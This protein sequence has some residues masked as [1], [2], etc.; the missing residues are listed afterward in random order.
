MPADPVPLTGSVR[1][2]DVRNTRRSRS[3][4][5]SSMRRNSGSRWPSTG[6]ASAMV[7]SGYGFD[8]PGPM[9]RRS[10]IPTGASWQVGNHLRQRGQALQQAR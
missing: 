6:A 5:S 7:T 9:S 2:F 8:G 3:F 10:D 4:V 1:A